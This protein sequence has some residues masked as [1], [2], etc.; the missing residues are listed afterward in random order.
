M[1]WDSYR[2]Q[3]RSEKNGKSG[4]RNCVLASVSLNPDS[5][6]LSERL[7]E[8]Q[9]FP[10]IAQNTMA[11]RF[12][13]EMAPEPNCLSAVEIDA[14]FGEGRIDFLS[15]PAEAS[16]EASWLDAPMENDT[17]EKELGLLESV[18]EIAIALARTTP[19]RNLNLD[20]SPAIQ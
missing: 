9:D 14:C 13:I 12:R 6:E 18:Q 17:F 1:D 2:S 20:S 15:E 3:F 16:H 7:N 11:N 19:K 5:A 10:L 8:V 4:N